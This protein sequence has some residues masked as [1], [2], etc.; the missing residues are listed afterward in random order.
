M[1]NV[2]EKIFELDANTSK[3][4]KKL[5]QLKGVYQELTEEQVKQV[6]ELKQLE[7]QEQKLK[8]VRDKSNNPTSYIQINKLIDENNKK[9]GA[10]RESVDKFTAN[11]HKARVEVS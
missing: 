7:I 5:Q 10:L 4:I 2:V 8:A 6:T 11:N 1:A 3:I 9:L